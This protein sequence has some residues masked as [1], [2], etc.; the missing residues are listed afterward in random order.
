MKLLTIAVGIGIGIGYLAADEDARNK[1]WAR[2]K[3]AKESTPAKSLEDK[4]SG[5]VSQLSDRRRSTHDDTA[6]WDDT[7][8]STRDSPAATPLTSARSVIS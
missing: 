2:L 5:A 1:A 6:I 8:L 7:T 4:V 3:Q